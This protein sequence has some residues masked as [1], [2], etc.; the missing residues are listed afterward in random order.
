MYRRR[1]GGRPALG[2][3]TALKSPRDAAVLARSHGLAAVRDDGRG[4]SRSRKDAREDSGRRRAAA[5]I[6]AGVGGSVTAVTTGVVEEGRR[7]NTQ[8]CA[9]RRAECG[10]EGVAC[11]RTPSREARRTEARRCWAR[12]AGRWSRRSAAEKD[13]VALGR[14]TLS[15]EQRRCPCVLSWGGRRADRGRQRALGKCKEQNGREHGPWVRGG[16]AHARDRT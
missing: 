6:A 15:K 16:R 12:A 14:S 5:Q 9:R 1:C 10:A 3:G 4:R 13:G 7:A 2:Q 11:A 8:R